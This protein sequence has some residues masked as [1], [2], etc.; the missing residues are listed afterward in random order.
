[1]KNVYVWT[2]RRLRS[3]LRRVGLLAV[4]DRWAARSRRGVWTRSLL[5]IYDPAE[6]LTLDVPWW[7]FES[8]DLVAD[9]LA[10]HPDARVFEW[11]SGSSTLWLAKRAGSVISVEHDVEW[12]ETVRGMLPKN[13]DLR[14]V[15]PIP[16]TS[17]AAVT[18]SKDGFAG[19]DFTA[20]VE[21]IDK[22]QGDFDL[23]VVDGRAREACF[24]KAVN[25]VA[26]GGRI[27]FDNVDRKRYVEAI[28]A[29][30][31]PLDVTWTR[32]LTPSL[33]YPTRTAVI[34]TAPS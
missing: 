23:I 11:G 13:C 25:R 32:G 4:L 21:E 34:A 28:S 1:M 8:S 29:S 30:A 19:L 15:P 3:L 31:V 20:Y 7:T 9:F 2:L 12:A 27:L 16:A 18:S 5:S 26:P 6:L 10:T 33:P 24:A 14:A 17:A 22:V